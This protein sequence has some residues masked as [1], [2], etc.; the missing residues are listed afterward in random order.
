MKR[1]LSVIILSL[2][3][4]LCASAASK[5][6]RDFQPVC[7]SLSVLMKERTGVEVVLKLKSV[8]RRGNAL[9]F[10]FTETLGDYPWRHA[11][12]GWFE[13]E[14]GSL[15][16]EGYSDC[17]VGNIFCKSNRLEEYAMDEIRHDGKPFS[18][19]FRTEDIRYVDAP[20]VRKVGE[21]T[22]T[23]GLSERHI[24]LWQSHGL[25][26]DNNNDNWTWQRPP[27][28]ETVEDLYTQ[29]YVLPF[30]VPMLENAGA[31]VLLPRERDCSTFETICQPATSGKKSVWH[32][33]IDV[34]G[35]YALYVSYDRSTST[36]AHYTVHHRGGETEYLVNQT[37]GFGMWV[38]LGSFEWDGESRVE[39]DNRDEAG[40]T[41]SAGRIKIGGGIGVSDRPRFVEGARYWMEYAGVDSTVWDQNK[42]E[43]DYRDDFM[44][45]GS[46]VRWLSAGSRLNPGEF[47]P[48]KDGD[49]KLPEKRP[50]RNIPIDLA[51]ALHT[52]AGITPNDSIVGT[53][54]IYTLK[55]DDSRELPTGED[56][57][58]SRQFADIVQSQV[59]NDIRKSF[60]PE[61][62]RRQ[63]WDRSYSE[64]RTTGTPAMLLELLSHQ[65]YA[66]MK[67]G[68]DPAFRFTVSRAIYKG[69]LK[70]LSC[71]YG[72][73]YVV[74]PLPVNSFEARLEGS[75]VTLSWKETIDGL[76]PTARAGNYILYTRI[77]DMDFDN[78]QIVSGTSVSLKIEP[79][80]I[81]SFR[82]E[83]MNEGGRSFPSE[84]LSVGT[85]GKES[86]GNVLI[87]NNFTRVSGPLFR[88]AAES[89]TGF[90]NRVDGGV[91]YVYDISYIGDMYDFNR[92]SE[93]KTNTCPGFGAS[94]NDCADKVIAGNSFDYT[95]IHG[96]GVMAA[97][98]SF[99][100]CSV[101]AFCEYG[102]GNAGSVDL[103]CGKQLRTLVGRGKE[104]K[105]AVF[106]DSLQ[107]AIRKATA[108]G[109]SFLVSGANVAT[110][111]FSAIYDVPTD[112]PECLKAQAFAKD[113]L[114]Y[115]LG[116]SFGSRSGMVKAAVTK[117][118]G[119]T[120]QERNFAYNNRL[121]AHMY[122]VEAPDGLVPVGKS[123]KVIYRYSD[124]G[125]C[126][127]VSYAPGGYRT[128][129][130]GF[131][132]ETITDQD[133]VND[134]LASSLEFF[135]K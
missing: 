116:T 102:A 94:Y 77:G 45:R 11:D 90:D 26:Y 134:I 110:D 6:V 76:E 7:D 133:A 18:D 100:S 57:L 36:K 48:P 33:Q 118:G 55:C 19:R 5:A 61:W 69:M 51:F 9:D 80:K 123:G 12:L 40:T 70:Y 58:T 42:G 23:K 50:G 66:D 83:A 21:P 10:V 49:G 87:V 131:P 122:C 126:A 105:Y 91:P 106:P 64:S 56:R 34:K 121:S 85:P 13:S 65:N 1:L 78:G 43:N 130:L 124:S 97:G 39:L 74:Q 112:T 75:R 79:G 44:S 32:P 30:L 4:A 81:Y 101:S 82:I 2:G 109:V 31:N 132:I 113:V 52:D 54:A 17:S 16:P 114:G 96:K 15:F 60:E 3:L 99:S 108:S 93:Y 92:A 103:I 20:L 98:Y 107:D 8:M 129:V 24:A 68:L 27:L 41:I 38:Y 104:E 28:F 71:R 29:S 128:I 135:S 120:C 89:W 72:C 63:T 127:G 59:V 73:P 111:V 125:T 119:Y 86:K 117:A 47:E 67:Y 14:L 25:Y 88:E 62:S 53:L 37:M 95:A 46:W 115:K 84:T 22:Y 35:R